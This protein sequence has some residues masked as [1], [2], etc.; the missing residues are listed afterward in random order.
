MRTDL[1][2]GLYAITD[3][4]P[5]RDPEF[6]LTTAQQVLAGGA[7][8]LQYRDKVNTID[9]RRSL[10]QGL[11]ELCRA[12]R[13]PLIV[14]DD[15]ELA[16]AVGADGVHLGKNDGSVEAARARLGNRIIGVSCYNDFSRAVAAERAGADYVAFGRFFVSATKPS[17][18]QAEV[19]L[20]ERAKA[21]LAVP[22]VAIGGITAANASTLL[23]AGVDLVAVVHAVFGAPE[24]AAAARRFA[25]LFECRNR[26]AAL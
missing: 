16:T 3:V 2:P 18:A 17:A 10:A 25:H 12:H 21:E 13:V 20:I 6:V 19:S 24:P 14:N 9:V 7:V 11:L 22:V 26:T 1:R 4:T 15:V 23:H 5:E 8:L